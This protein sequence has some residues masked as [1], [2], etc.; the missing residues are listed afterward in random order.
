MVARLI[1]DSTQFCVFMQRLKLSRFSNGFL[2][3][4][5]YNDLR[6]DLGLRRRINH[7]MLAHRPAHKGSEWYHKFW[8]P[9]GISPEVA[10]FVYQALAKYSGL[11]VTKVLPTDRL[12]E[13]L[14]LPLVCWFDWELCLCEDFYQ[15]FGLA[16]DDYLDV[17]QF[18]TVADLVG[19]L[20]HQLLA[21]I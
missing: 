4:R 12:C 18:K 19:F 10:T 9:R 2:A 21:Q 20:N 6:P 13:D 17:T 15:E 8:E 14:K 1:P 5:S 16:L 3:L 11:Q 7:Q